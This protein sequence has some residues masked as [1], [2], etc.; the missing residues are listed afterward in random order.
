MAHLSAT[1]STNSHKI[2]GEH[3]AL[4]EDLNRLNRALDRLDCY[5]EVYA[6]LASADE[7]GNY[8]RRLIELLPEHFKRE[9]ETVLKPVAEVSPQLDV[10]VQELKKEHEDLRL[11]LAAFSGALEDLYA[12]DDIYQ[13]VWHV[14]DLGKSFVRDL[15][16]HVEL[17]EQ[18]LAGFL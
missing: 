6:N 4:M 12:A 3:Q 9:E 11:G 17:E 15:F 1:F 13:A 14:K 8:S 5:S 18:E 7:V 2:H 16:R 10:L